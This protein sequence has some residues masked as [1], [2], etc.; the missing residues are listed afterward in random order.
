MPK[1]KSR[2]RNPTGNERKKWRPKCGGWLTEW[3]VGYT[4]NF[5]CKQTSS[6]TS[7][8]AA[9]TVNWTSNISGCR[10]CRCALKW[11]FVHSIEVCVFECMDECEF[12]MGIV[13]HRIINSHEYT[14][15]THVYL[16]GIQ[17]EKKKE[18][19]GRCCSKKGRTG[20]SRVKQERKPK[21][22]THGTSLLFAQK[23]IK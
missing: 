12:G 13:R 7:A 19:R 23:D 11:V 10:I 14:F 22:T 20:R 6:K 9:R 16:E 21:N 2:F 3:L 1:Q 5:Y 17:E 4:V 18:I 15:K 8:T